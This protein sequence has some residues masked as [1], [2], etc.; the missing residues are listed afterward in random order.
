MSRMGFATG[1]DPPRIGWL[2]AVAAN[3]DPADAAEAL[4]REWEI[5]MEAWQ[6]RETFHLVV[7]EADDHP[8]RSSRSMPA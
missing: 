7:N 6:R 2:L 4:E 8:L 5:E 3:N 1:Y